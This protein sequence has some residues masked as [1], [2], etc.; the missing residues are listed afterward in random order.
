MPGN[1][2]GV[3]RAGPQEEPAAPDKKR[4]ADQ[5]SRTEVDHTIGGAESRGP[6][7]VRQLLD[8][9]TPPVLRGIVD[10]VCG[11]SRG[12]AGPEGAWC[13][14]CLG[15]CKAYTLRL[16]GGSGATL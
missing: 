5:A 11:R 4:P 13:D 3:Q 16:D 14:C 6:D 7:W 12:V 1:A 2:K 15:E 10:L 8:P 9:D